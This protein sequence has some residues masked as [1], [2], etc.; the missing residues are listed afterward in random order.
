MQNTVGKLLEKHVA[1]Q[2]A[3]ELEEKDISPQPLAATEER[4]SHG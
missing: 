4:R 1:H 3:T 2:L